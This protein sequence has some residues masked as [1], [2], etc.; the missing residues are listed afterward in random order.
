MPESGARPLT[1]LGIY[2]WDRFWS[3]GELKGAPSFFLAPQALIEA[4]HSVHISMPKD[5]AGA[6]TETYH[7]MKLRRYG[8]VLDFMPMKGHPLFIHL[9]RPFRYL[10]YLALATLAGLRAARACKPDVVVGYGAWA[11]PVAFF[12]ARSL[13]LPNV[14][15]LFGQSLSFGGGAGLR[16][17]VRTF[18]N[19]PEIVAF[20]TSCSTLIVC[21]DGSGGDAVARRMGVPA[22]KIRF[23]R[24]GVDKDLFCPPE[25]RRKAKSGLGLDPDAPMLLSVSRLDAEK[26]HERLIHALPE[27]LTTLPGAIVY[28]LGEGPE[29]E[30]L[31]S[32][33]SRLGLT[34]SVKMPGAVPQETLARHYKAC[35]VFLSLS[36]RTNVA[37]P[38]LEAMCCGAP[39][40]A[41]DAGGAP[42]AVAAGDHVVAVKKEE[43]PGLGEIIAGLIEDSDRR[44]VLGKS[45]SR[46]AETHVPSIKE[47][48]QMEAGAVSAAVSF[49]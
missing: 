42:S 18:L 44:S 46:F 12:V 19:Y 38:T 43:L 39:V 28:I 27:V 16:G 5:A 41:L 45:A 13:G 1:V 31:K 25:D 35:D 6:R 24:N 10:F 15:R 40:V 36:D 29:R 4:G 14:T 49:K 20:L 3:M 11:A 48:S 30:Y 7:G 33:A 32:E 37:N 9:T 22:D 47:R 23:W 26:H 17:A 21:D 8:F 2:P 34:Q